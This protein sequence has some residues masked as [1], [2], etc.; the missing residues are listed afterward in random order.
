VTDAPENPYVNAAAPGVPLSPGEEKQFA[1]LDH[2]LSIFFGFIPALIFFVMYRDRGPFVRAHTVTE[3]NFQLTMLIFQV[4]GFLLA[5]VSIF[6]STMTIV[7]GTQ[8][9]PPPGIALFFVGYLLVLAVRVVVII[10][11]IIASM[12]T[13]RGELYRYPLAFAFV[14]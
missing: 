4:A 9:G 8:S 12:A 2:L 14:K 11:G 10:F 1:L 3:W 6:V 5:F 7:P 13:S